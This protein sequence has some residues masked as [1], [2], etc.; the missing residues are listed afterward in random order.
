MWI[1]LMYFYSY[2]Y[3]KLNVNGH[4]GDVRS[5]SDAPTPCISKY[6]FTCGLF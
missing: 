1:I 5:P 6:R 4:I 3:F 2:F